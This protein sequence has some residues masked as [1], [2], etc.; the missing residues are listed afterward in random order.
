MPPF[1]ASMVKRSPGRRMPPARFGPSHLLHAPLFPPNP[2]HQAQEL[3]EAAQAQ[4][5]EAFRA[6]G[7]P[8]GLEFDDAPLLPGA[9]LLGAFVGSLLL[10]FG[11]APLLPA[12]VFSTVLEAPPVWGGCR[13][14]GAAGHCRCTAALRASL[15][16]APCH[17][18]HPPCRR[19]RPVHRQQRRAGRRRRQEAQGGGAVAVTAVAGLQGRRGGGSRFCDGRCGAGWCSV[20]VPW[21]MLLGGSGSLLWG[22]GE[23]R[24]AAGCKL[25]GCAPGCT[26]LL[27]AV[28]T[29]APSPRARAARRRQAAAQ[30]KGLGDHAREPGAAHFVEFPNTLAPEPGRRCG[31]EGTG[32]PR[33]CSS[34]T[35]GAWFGRRRL[36]PNRLETCAIP[37]AQAAAARCAWPQAA[38]EQRAAML[39]E[40]ARV[41][42]E[43][44]AAQ[45]RKARLVVLRLA[46]LGVAWRG[47]AEHT[48]CPP[49]AVAC[50][51]KRTLHLALL[52]WRAPL[53]APPPACPRCNACRSRSGCCA[54]RRRRMRGW[55]KSGRRSWRGWRRSGANT[56]SGCRR[57][58]QAWGSDAGVGGW[59]P[60]ALCG[61]GPRRS[62]QARVWWAGLGRPESVL[63][64]W[65]ALPVAG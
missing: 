54:T 55:R 19:R 48:G 3:V 51:G 35:H 25:S 61:G 18:S 15:P 56:S 41:Q 30:Q 47:C 34:G 23:G 8:L 22:S 44:L 7:P 43:R 13:Q 9:A 28:L 46:W 36:C 57:S 27:A 33:R 29:A 20:A 45:I 50:C 38:E 5:G 53:S 32:G 21:F 4:M 16:D 58:R 52:A 17:S 31:G 49:P 12:Q 24:P 60:R 42:Q 64:C 63:G 62:G 37:S 14:R 1:N 59:G 40:R 39:A 65:V 11:D 2:T 6:D 10:A 26:C